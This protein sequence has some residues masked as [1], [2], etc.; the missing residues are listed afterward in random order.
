M[1]FALT[2]VFSSCILAAGAAWSAEDDT[3]G[4]PSAGQNEDNPVLDDEQDVVDVFDVGE[5]KLKEQETEQAGKQDAT[6]AEGPVL[7]KE[8][9]PPLRIGGAV[10]TGLGAAALIAAAITGGLALGIDNDLDATKCPEGRCYQE[11]SDDV[12]RRDNLALST[13]ILLISGS[14]AVVAGVLMVVFSYPEF[15][16]SAKKG[17]KAETI[18][19]RPIIGRSCVGTSIAWSF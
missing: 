13:D 9:T 6:L 5:Q 15:N 16:P 19:V 7:K 3:V 10:T 17:Q 8:P 1:K 18:T 4:V 12:D 14:T 2:L 11:Y